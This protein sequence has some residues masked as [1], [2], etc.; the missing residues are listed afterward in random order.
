MSQKEQLL[1][2]IEGL[3]NKSYAVDI[4]CNEFTRIYNLEINYDDLTEKENQYFGELCEISARFS[5][6]KED[7]KIPKIYSSEEEI[8]T[9]AKD[10]I[11]ELGIY[12]WYYKSI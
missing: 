4:F 3:L 7:M 8:V 6:N 5:N 1:Y 9:K 10:I 2:L 11:K 12:D